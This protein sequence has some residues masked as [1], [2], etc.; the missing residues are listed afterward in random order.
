L[1]DPDRPVAV[2][3]YRKMVRLMYLTSFLALSLGGVLSWLIR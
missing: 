3:A 1:G 2:D